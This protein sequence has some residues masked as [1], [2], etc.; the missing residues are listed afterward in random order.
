MMKRLHR[1][2]N[3]VVVIAKADS[4]TA[5]EVRRLKANIL[6]D[7]DLH[8]IQVTPWNY[9][10][11]R[12]RMW[13]DDITVVFYPKSSNQSLIGAEKHREETGSMAC[14]VHEPALGQR[15]GL[16]P[17]SSS[18]LVRRGLNLGGGLFKSL[19]WMG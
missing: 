6:H 16:W 11:L 4:L 15:C 13:I 14:L 9:Y 12:K 17:T 19:I 3:I 5:A 18:S 7:L 10:T 8:Q 2:V 1:K